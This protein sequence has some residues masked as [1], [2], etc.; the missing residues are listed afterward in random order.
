MK[1]AVVHFLPKTDGTDGA[2]LRHL[3]DALRSSGHECTVI[4]A[5]ACRGNFSL[6]HYDYIAMLISGRPFFGAELPPNFRDILTESGSLLG[7]KSAALV[8]KRGFC[9]GKLCTR[10][11]NAMETEG[12]FVD[13]F[14]II[15]NAAH[16]DFIGKK[17]IG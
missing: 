17:R 16:A 4:D 6:N 10:L 13:Y 5:A 14:E 3:S 11:M 12:M 9:A 15:E 2:I 7:K 1:I 8:T